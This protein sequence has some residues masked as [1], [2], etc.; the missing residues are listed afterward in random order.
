MSLNA[1]APSPTYSRERPRT[2]CCARCKSPYNCGNTA[3]ACHA[4]IIPVEAAL[5]VA[6]EVAEREREE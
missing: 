3:C 2:R 5:A 4:R 1:P 6:A